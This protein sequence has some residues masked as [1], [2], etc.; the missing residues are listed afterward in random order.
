MTKEKQKKKV[1]IVDDS[2]TIQRTAE[3]LLNQEGYEVKVA[4]DGFEA[5]VAVVDFRPDIIFLDIMMPRL[6]GYQVCSVLKNNP[7]YA[8]IPVIMLSSKDSVFDRARGRVVGANHFMSKPF[9]KE[10]LIQAI[11]QYAI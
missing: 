8:H 5:F 1:L 2:K 6:D 11:Q 10:V 7:S 3:M 9:S 4:T